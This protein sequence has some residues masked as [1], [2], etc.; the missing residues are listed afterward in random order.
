M[1]LIELTPIEF[2]QFKQLAHL[3]HFLFVY[4]GV[5][6]GSVLVEADIEALELLGY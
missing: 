1:K 5:H 2:H 4:I 6:N 3:A